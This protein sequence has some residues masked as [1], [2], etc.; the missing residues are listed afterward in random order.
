MEANRALVDI[1]LARSEAIKRG[2]NVYICI[3]DAQACDTANPSTC[4]CGVGVEATRYDKGWLIFVD[5]DKDDDF[6]AD[7]EELLFVGLP[8]N[9]VVTMESNGT[10]KWGIGLQANG[11]I[12]KGDQ[13]GK[14]AVCYNG[15]SSEDLLGRKITINMSGRT[16]IKTMNPGESCTPDGA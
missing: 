11:Q 2:K 13:N 5:E 9:D 16:V 14:I 4:Q 12:A 15:E 6:D 1:Q 10:I 3:T 8:P 7:T